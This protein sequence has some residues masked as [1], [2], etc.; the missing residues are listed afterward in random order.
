M[1]EV[2]FVYDNVALPRNP[3]HPLVGSSLPREMQQQGGAEPSNTQVVVSIARNMHVTGIVWDE[4]DP[5]AVVE[6]EVVHRG[7]E[8]P[9]GVV[10]ED[11]EPT[12][13]VLRAG[14]SQIPIDLEER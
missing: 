7:Y 11:I 2:D 1:K 8:F 13:V 5:I 12:R 4:N 3:M 14:E 10:V 9:T 6:D